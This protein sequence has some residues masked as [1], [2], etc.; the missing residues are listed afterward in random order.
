MKSI[1]L[2]ADTRGW[3]FHRH[4]DEIKKR[5]TNYSFD[6]KFS[7]QDDPYKYNYEPYDLVYQLDPMGIGGLHTPREK[8]VIGL[9]NEFMYG[10]SRDELIAFYLSTFHGK[11]KIV[12]VV[13]RKQLREFSSIPMAMPLM[14]VQHGVDTDCFKVKDKKPV[15]KDGPLVVAIAG[16][17]TSGCNKGFEIVEEAGRI[18]GCNV[19]TAKQ[20]LSSGH[21]TKEQMADFYNTIDVYCCMSSTNSEGINNC[22]MEA[23]AT[24]VPVIATLAGAVDETVEDGKNGFV[25]ERS[26]GA[27]VDKLNFFKNNREAIPVF[28]NELMKKITSNWSWNTRI[29]D[30]RKMFDAFFSL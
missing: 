3:I 19:V 5:I 7:W 11:Y 1:L 16:N 30:Y 2:I 26:V 12:H 17:H 13:N 23:G 29:E 14:L 15:S 6:I 27:L 18:T 25:I 20:N 9:R 22:I 8:T 10:H 4:C 21:L 24:A 28:G